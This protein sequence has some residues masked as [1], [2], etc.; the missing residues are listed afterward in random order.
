M[1][2]TEKGETISGSA[3]SRRAGA[4]LRRRAGLS[5]ERPQRRKTGPEAEGYTN[6]VGVGGECKTLACLREAGKGW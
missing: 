3:R 5:I 2:D 1:L 6:S 4:R